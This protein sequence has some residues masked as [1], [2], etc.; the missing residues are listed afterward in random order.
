MTK[1]PCILFC[2]FIRTAQTGWLWKSRMQHRVREIGVC[3]R[4]C[5]HACVRACV[6]VCVCVLY[7]YIYVYIYMNIIYEYVY[8]YSYIYIYIY[9]YIYENIYIYIYIYSYIYVGNAGGS[10]SSSSGG[11]GRHKLKKV[12]KRD[13]THTNTLACQRTHISHICGCVIYIESV[14]HKAVVAGTN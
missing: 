2:T 14:G 10:N 7:I 13:S 5:M 12:C 6:R 3:V 4:T 11:G 8:I 9:I 1:T